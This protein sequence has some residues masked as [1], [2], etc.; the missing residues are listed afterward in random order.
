MKDKNDISCDGVFSF[1]DVLHFYELFG[2]KD[3]GFGWNM[4][5]NEGIIY[6]Y[7]GISTL[8]FKMNVIY[9]MVISLQICVQKVLFSLKLE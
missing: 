9:I 3:E 1:M 4:N 8:F 5:V 7:K 2:N 6:V